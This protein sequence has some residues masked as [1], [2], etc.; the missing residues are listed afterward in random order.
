ME[1]FD[2]EIRYQLRDKEPVD[3]KD[4]QKK[5]I[6]IDKNMQTYGKYNLLGF[7][8]GASSKKIEDKKKKSEVHE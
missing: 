1:S 7:T 3:L 8:R 6:K 2:G 4:A 5:A